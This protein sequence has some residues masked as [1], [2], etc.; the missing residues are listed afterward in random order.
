MFNVFNHLSVQPQKIEKSKTHHSWFL[1]N[2]VGWFM[3]NISWKYLPRLYLMVF[4]VSWQNDVQYKRYIQKCTLSSAL[5]S[6]TTWQLLKLMEWFKIWKLNIS[7]TKHDFSFKNYK[8]L[9]LC[10]KNCIFRGYG[11][12]S[13]NLR[14]S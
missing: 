8:I 2:Y 7:K 10:L 12:R 3:Q 1:I 4:H 9:K 14:I 11:I 6:I 13:L 5:I